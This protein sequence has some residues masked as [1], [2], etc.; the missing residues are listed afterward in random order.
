MVIDDIIQLTYHLELHDTIA[1]KV[2]FCRVIG[3][4]KRED[5]IVLSREN[6]VKYEVWRPQDIKVKISVKKLQAWHIPCCPS[7]PPAHLQADTTN[8]PGD[9]LPCWEWLGEQDIMWH[10]RLVLAMPEVI[11]SDP[12]IRQTPHPLGSCKMQ[13][14]Q[15][16]AQFCRFIAE[17]L[18]FPLLFPQKSEN[19]AKAEPC[20]LTLFLPWTSWVL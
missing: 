5:E 14:Q 10:D 7:T 15:L 19:R 12:V 9:A 16:L 20:V 4:K 6:T 8:S 17:K 2:V 1:S 11:F 18:K 3:R 13:V